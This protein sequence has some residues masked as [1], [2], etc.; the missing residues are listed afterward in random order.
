M[1]KSNSSKEDSN[2]YTQLTIKD[3]IF[4]DEDKEE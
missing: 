1:L 4:E 2:N 3:T